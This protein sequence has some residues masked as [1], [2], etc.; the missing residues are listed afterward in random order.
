MM[1]IYDDT[2][3]PVIFKPPTEIQET[4]TKHPLKLFNT[5]VLKAL[6]R[7]D[8]KWIEWKSIQY[9]QVNQATNAWLL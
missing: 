8:S 9:T 5:I 3:G 1:D 4:S 2:Q 7:S 6:L